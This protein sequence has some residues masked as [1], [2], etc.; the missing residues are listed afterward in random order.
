MGEDFRLGYVCLEVSDLAGFTT[1]MTDIAGFAAGGHAD[2]WSAFRLDG[3]AARLLCREGPAND[4]VASGWDMVDSEALERAAARLLAVGAVIDRDTAELA[5]QRKAEQVL[6]TRDFHGTAVE[7]FI[8]QQQAGP[9]DLPLVAG[10]FLTSDRLGLGHLVLVSRDKNADLAFYRDA[11]GLRWSDDI[12]MP[13][14]PFGN[15]DATFLHANPRHHSL[16][17]GSLPDPL[18]LRSRLDHICFEM[19]AIDDVGMAHARFVEAGLPIVRDFG[20]HPNDRA[21][22]FYGKT[23][24]GFDFELA[25]DSALIDDETWKPQTYAHITRWGHRSESGM[26]SIG[27]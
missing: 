7:L 2:G 24:A 11:L 18:P 17:V 26:P 10:G 23:P 21:F 13:L 19:R 25:F 20:M 12:I 15:L 3:A 16:A 4:I 14:G 6:A 27:D 22:S 1:F 5:R 8:G 9:V